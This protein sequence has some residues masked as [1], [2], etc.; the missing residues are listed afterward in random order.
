[1][2]KTFVLM[3][4][5]SVY[6]LAQTATVLD[7]KTSKP[8]VLVSV[9]SG[10]LNRALITDAQG[11]V[12]I[13]SLKGSETIIFRLIGYE[14]LITSYT[15]LENNNFTVYMREHPISLGNVIVAAK[16]WEE[17]R[18][19]IPNTIEFIGPQE[20]EFQNPQ[21]AADL[22]SQSGNVYVQ[23][24]QLGG[25]SPM[26]RG[27][28]A[29]RVLIVVDNVRMNTAI[30]RSGNLQNVI[31]VDAN[32]LS[33]A[34][35]I[36]GPGS[37]IYGSDAI[38][39]VMEF[40]TSIPQ[41]SYS[42]DILLNGNVL[43][44][45]SSANKEKTGHLNFNFGFQQWSFLTSVTYSKFGDLEMGSEGPGDYLRKFYQERINGEDVTLP[46]PDPDVQIGSDYDQIN[47]MQKIRFKPNDDWEFN[48]GFHYSSTSDVPRYDRLIE[49]SGGQ[50]K[51]AQWYYG[52]QKWMMNALS[53]TNFSKSMFYDY[54]K[55]I[56][57]YQNFEESRNDRKFGKDELRH[58][59]ETVDALSLNLDFVKKINEQSQIY[60]GAESVFNKVGSI[61]EKENI[62]TGQTVAASTRYPDG[63][64]WNSYGA[65]LTYKNRFSEKYILQTGLRYNLVQLSAEFDTT[66]Y[67]LPFKDADLTTGA[68]TGSV[69]FVWH[70]EYDW[71]IN[72]NLS[73][74]FRAPNID[75]IGKIFDSEPG[76]VVVPNPN[77]ESEYIYSAELGMMKVFANRFQFDIVG[78]YSYLDNALVRRDFTLN[79]KD[80]IQYDGTLSQVQS[81][82]NAAFAYVWG[83]QTGIDFKI[84]GEL[85]L[86]SKFTYQKGEEEDD[87]GNKV[88]MRH[89]APWYGTTRL[90]FTKDDLNLMLYA[91]YNGEVSYDDL[92]PS[93]REK[94]FIYALD[95]NENPYSPAWT[96]FNIKVGLRLFER[97]MLNL[98]IENIFDKRY[99][100]YSSGISAPGRNY[101]ASV[102]YNF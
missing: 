86:I 4:V 37:V 19:D 71:Q 97:F 77:L 40:N 60:Y 24:S 63:S 7:E 85:E 6:A 38:G 58:R 29:N 80:S 55:I 57:A 11:N 35:V 70:P 12:D 52:P 20:V 22:L 96:T 94:T 47:A 32:S 43:T 89:S 1:M 74:G 2:L 93:E 65:Y 26:I 41:F 33:N 30:F 36:F 101:I 102:K 51:S 76:S 8:L 3:F 44:R 42:D 18:G 79:G 73:T 25:G 92:A 5:L 62:F 10:D 49:M 56:A 90:V 17:E 100:T 95:D 46:N 82:Q 72:L 83:L 78:F 99:R 27:F 81:I 31:S 64:D 98:G 45:Y 67:P 9:Y 84:S 14:K 75:D 23:K 87:A 21:T 13:T 39:G 48:Y 88:S 91:D 15:N 28:A 68:L 54:T 66:F 61:G 50:M 59:T 34:Q 69:G 16:R 53:V